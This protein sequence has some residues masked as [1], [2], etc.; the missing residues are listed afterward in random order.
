MTNIVMANLNTTK[1]LLMV[2]LKKP[3][4]SGQFS[5]LLAQ[6]HLQ[7]AIGYHLVQTYIPTGMIV[8]I[9]WV[10]FWIDPNAVPA[11]VSLSFTTL[12]TLA[13]QVF[14]E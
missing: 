4:I 2:T 6:I 10:S 9:S 1:L 7:R 11:R 12:L 14:D 13:T 8:V 3:P 5:C